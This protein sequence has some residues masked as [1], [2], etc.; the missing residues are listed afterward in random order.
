M[1]KSAPRSI[2]Q[3]LRWVSLVGEDGAQALTGAAASFWVLWQPPG[4]ATLGTAGSKSGHSQLGQYQYQGGK[5]CIL[6]RAKKFKILFLG[7]Q[8]STLPEKNIIS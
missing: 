7:L 1:S 6:R 5:K 4:R 8:R 2:E 3:L